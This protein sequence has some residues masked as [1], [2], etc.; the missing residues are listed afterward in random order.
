VWLLFHRNAKTRPVPD[1][2]TFVETCPVCGQ[3]ATFVEVEI[4][5]NYGLFFV[6]LIVDKE[7]AYRC[8]A[9]GDTFDLKDRPAASAPAATRPSTSL[10]EL[11]RQQRV[12]EERRRAMAEA[13]ANRIEDELA[14]L[15]KRMGR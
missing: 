3:R 11:E 13:K 4:V 7:R 2:D 9:C 1:G 6:D 15:K 10:Q 8:C 5:E 14:E 12:D